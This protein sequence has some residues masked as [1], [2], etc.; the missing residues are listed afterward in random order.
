MAGTKSCAGKTFVDC[1]GGTPIAT[2]CGASETCDAEAGCVHPTRVFA[3]S[4]HACA[5]MSDGTAV[6]WGANEAGQL[7]TG[8][9]AATLPPGRVITN[10]ATLA[11]L[12]NVKQL[13]LGDAS[14]CAVIDDGA[15]TPK[16]LCWGSDKQGQL[17]DGASDS[18]RALPALNQP[19]ALPEAVA[20][21]ATGTVSSGG[22]TTCAVGTTGKVYC[23]G[24][25]ADGQ[26]GN[27]ASAQTSGVPVGVTGISGASTLSVGTFH[28][29]AVG[30]VGGQAG[31]ACWGSENV[32][33]LGNG[34][35]ALGGASNT[36][37]AA[38]STASLNF[39][40]D[41]TTTVFAGGAEVGTQS[42]DPT[43]TTCALR[44]VNV[45]CW[46]ASF[47]GQVG[48]G[49]FTAQKFA[50][51]TAGGALAGVNVAQI[52]TSWGHACARPTGGGKIY[53]WGSNRAGELGLPAGTANSNVPVAVA[54]DVV[55][56]AVG[57]SSQAVQDPV[58]GTISI[59]TLGFTCGVTAANEVKCLGTNADGQQG[60]SGPTSGIST[61]VMP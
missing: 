3:G 58:D 55:D 27:G 42:H 41:A 43:G 36:A 59:E 22:Y 48:Q 13:A 19:V 28:A 49:S 14:T 32:G 46:G 4:R 30:T 39:F 6:C 16:V 37:V 26:L 20:V 50:T 1:S 7:G 51:S 35:I 21:G 47:Y 18:S 29:C 17:G 44:G 38:K 53:C 54:L 8:A 10:L 34:V 23:W 52:G 25:G 45:F 33:Q 11:P 5:L 15:T 24:A 9:T 60:T 12:R 56:M 40:S 61:V 57:A 2:Q 31:L